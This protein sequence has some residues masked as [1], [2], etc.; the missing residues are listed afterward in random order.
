MPNQDITIQF[1]SAK[2]DAL[3]Y[4]FQKYDT[5]IEAELAKHLKRLYQSNVPMKVKEYIERDI[6]VD[7][8]SD[9]RQHH[10]H[11]QTSVQTT[12]L[13]PAGQPEPLQETQE[14]QGMTM[15]M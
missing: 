8:N 9:N 3:D 12:V 2:Y 7:V 15:G 1:A 14:Y 11:S 6:N 4:F 5:T 13:T 10:G